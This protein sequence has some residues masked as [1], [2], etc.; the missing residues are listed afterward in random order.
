MSTGGPQ[1]QSKGWNTSPA[2]TGERSW[3]CSACIR[4]ASGR[5]ENSISVSK[6]ELKEERGQIL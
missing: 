4:E 6:G 2:R 1:K 3:G 5:P